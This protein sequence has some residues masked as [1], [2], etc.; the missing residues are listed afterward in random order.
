MI[1][2]SLFAIATM[3]L[4]TPAF[5][6]S[7][8]PVAS[9]PAA[10]PADLAPVD[11]AR[12]VAARQVIDQVWPLGTYERIMRAVMDQMVNGTLASM[13]DMP[14]DTFAKGLK[15]DGP[16]KSTGK[17]FR[18]ALAEDDPF[19]EERMRRSMN[20]M[21]GEM[22]ALMNE[23]EPDVRVAFANAYARRF[24][25][26]QLNDLHTF[27]QTPTGQI[28]AR[29]SMTLMMGPDMMKAMQAFAPKMME[30]MPAITAKVE[31]ATK[32]LPP[33]KRKTAQ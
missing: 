15:A 19:F 25:V 11:S 13:Y 7:M 33:P 30:R 8:P 22:T 6:Q 10:G 3:L 17:T 2:A 31:A 29:E 21:M 4:T 24:T 16:D 14:A 5:A 20:V 9:S 18:Q 26:A 12:L 1:R 28:Y 32:D 27:F 23:V